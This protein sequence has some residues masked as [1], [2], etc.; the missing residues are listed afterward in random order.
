MRSVTGGPFGTNAFTLLR[1]TNYNSTPIAVSSIT[2]AALSTMMVTVTVTFASAHGIPVGGY[3]LLK[4]DAMDVYNGIWKVLTVPSSA[5]LTFAMALANTTALP[6]AP[7]GS[8]TSASQTVAT[9]GVF[10]AAGNTFVP[11]QAVTIT[12]TPPGGFAT[13]TT[14]YVI[15]SFASG[16]TFQLA[17]SPYATT[18]IQCTSSSSCTIVPASILGAAADANI[19]ITGGGT[20]NNQFL[21]AGFV[22]QSLP[23]DSGL[24]FR[25]VLDLVVDG[26]NIVDNGQHAIMGQDL[27]HPKF[28]N[29]DFN[30]DS[31]CIHIYGR[32]TNP[33]V[34]NITGVSGND[35]VVFQP[36]E[37]S[38]YVSN[39]LGSGA[40]LGGDILNPIARN[41]RFKQSHGNSV[42]I[43]PSGNTGGGGALNNA[44]YK[45][46]GK[47][48][49]DGAG[50]QTLQNSITGNGWLANPTVAISGNYVSV[51]STLDNIELR[52]VFGY[53]AA[54]NNIPAVQL[55]I[56]NLVIEGNANDSALRDNGFSV[57]LD[58]VTIQ[59]LVLKNAS[60]DP[61]YGGQAV[62]VN[63]SHNTIQNASFNECCFQKTNNP[64]VGQYCLPIWYNGAGTL[65]VLTL[66]NCVLGQNA[67]VAAYTVAF[68]NTPQININNCVGNGYSSLISQSTAVSFNMNINGLTQLSAIQG[69]FNIYTAGGTI[70]INAA[71]VNVVAG[72]IWVNYAGTINFTNPDGTIPVDLSKITRTAGAF[73]KS[74]TGNGTIVANNMAICDATGAANSWKQLSNTA[75]VY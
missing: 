61:L 14:Y 17:V 7:A 3:V 25:R 20:I 55:P 68:A 37:I 32:T 62:Q 75:L 9:P 70:G 56:T 2:V 65:G 6:P 13:A 73:A 18:G 38:T 48:L 50:V 28:R 15:N 21:V 60:F 19:V 24:V 41:I 29:I 8:V 44:I 51:P 39:I 59:N 34:E 63:S 35:G 47:V 27:E 71:G 67:I 11:G 64:S 16:G 52:N 42:G 12:G 72:S 26:P 31:D 4:N 10:T 1:N 53:I 66:T 40:D 23:S 36:I 30:T 57:I 33:L 5:V 49:V 58:Y 43:Y 46:R 22:N 69:M 74:A 45:V 54:Q